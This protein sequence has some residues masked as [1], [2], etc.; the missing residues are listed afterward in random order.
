MASLEATVAELKNAKP[1]QPRGSSKVAADVMLDN[2]WA[3]KV[4]RKD[5][6]FWQGDSYEGQKWSACPPAYLDKLAASLEYSANK[7]SQNPDA[8]KN[9]KGEP[10]WRGTLF[11]ASLVRA[12]AAR[13]R[14]SVSLPS[15]SAEAEPA[16]DLPF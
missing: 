8:K 14:A 5:P 9:A 10:Y 13:K 6:K 4:V 1:S 16:E 2:S 3:D 12:W 7:E 15:P 11:E